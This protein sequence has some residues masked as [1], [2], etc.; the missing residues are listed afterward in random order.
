METLVDVTEVE[1]KTV[2]DFKLEM[3]DAD[4]ARTLDWAMENI[5]TAEMDALLINWAVVKI[6]KYAMENEITYEEIENSP[7]TKDGET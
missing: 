7:P 2:V 4:Y 6:L 5:S 3:D 1:R